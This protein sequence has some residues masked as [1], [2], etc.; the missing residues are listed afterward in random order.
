MIFDPLLGISLIIG[1]GY[2]GGNIARWLRLPAIIGNIGAGVLLGPYGVGLLSPQLI[3]HGLKPVNS[4]AFSFIAVSVALHLR[5][6]EMKELS[7]APVTIALCETLLAFFLVMGPVYLWTN[8]FALAVL[9]GIMA[10]TTAPA[11]GLAVVRESKAKGPFVSL[12]LPT[13]AFDNV[14][15]ILLFTSVMIFF[16]V[17]GEPIHLLTK[18]MAPIAIG[19]GVGSAF[20]FLPKSLTADNRKTLIVSLLGLMIASGVA[21]SLHTSPFLAAIALGFTLTNLAQ[22]RIELEEVYE[23]ISKSFREVDPLIYLIFFTIAGSHLRFDAILSSGLLIVLFLG[24]RFLG[25]FFGGFL[26]A[27]FSQWTLPIRC[28]LGLGLLPQAGLALGFLVLVQESPHLQELSPLLSAIVLSAVVV[29]EIAGPLSVRFVLRWVGEEGKAYPPALGFLQEKDIYLDL[30]AQDKWEAI[31]RLVRF[32]CVRH[33]IDISLEGKYLQGIINRELSL[34]TGIGHGLAIPHGV[35]PHR[36]KLMGALAI[37]HEGI[38]FGSLDGKPVHVILLTLVPEDR[39]EQHLDALKELSRTF[40]KPFV[41]PALLEARTNEE[42][43]EI[44]RE[45]S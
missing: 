22:W 31:S 45:A 39:L 37:S 30:E 4:L 36:G 12:L 16:G 17:K 7:G 13:I 44:L 24:G 43:L 5:L 15:A 34:T 1:L 27:S 28:Y 10:S 35:V 25:K 11:T 2:L 21:E 40:S 14:I 33:S 8:S 18:F 3:D 42:V 32:I 38:D 23:K 41:I 20:Y 26:G 9:C 19:I 6:R 29:N